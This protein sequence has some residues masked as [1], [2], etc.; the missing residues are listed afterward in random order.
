MS[1]VMYVWLLTIVD[2]YGRYDARPAILKSELFPFLQDLV[3][4]A[5]VQRSLENMSRSGLVRL[6]S[7]DGKP[8]LEI[9]KFRQ[10]LRAKRSKWPAPQDACQSHANA[11]QCHDNVV[12][13]PTDTDTETETD[14]EKESKPPEKTPAGQP[15]EDKNQK[16]N[17]TEPSKKPYGPPKTVE[18]PD[19]LSGNTE[20]ILAW[21]DYKRE[22][23]QGYKAKGLESLWRMIRSIHPGSRKAAIEQSMA[24]NYAGIF[25]PKGGSNGNSRIGATAV[26]GKYAHLSS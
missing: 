4:E 23:G 25:P 12:T 26:P 20:E 14:T 2:D 21:L 15:H 17:V 3:R 22:K 9:Q 11:G 5:D 10:R 16:E 8:Y 7:H 1:G 24:C 19:D 6:Y 18:I 13:M